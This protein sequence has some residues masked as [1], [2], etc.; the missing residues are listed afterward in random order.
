MRIKNKL[1]DYTQLSMFLF[2]ISKWKYVSRDRMLIYIF[3]PPPLPSPALPTL[4]S[5]TL[6]YPPQPSPAL[7]LPSPPFP[8]SSLPSPLL[9]SSYPPPSFPSPFN[10]CVFYS[11]YLFWSSNLAIQSPIVLS[12][13]EM[14]RVISVCC[15]NDFS[16]A[17]TGIFKFIFCNFRRTD[18]GQRGDGGGGG[19]GE[20]RRKEVIYYLINQIIHDELL[21]QI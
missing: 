19:G 14:K 7:P 18:R 12:T 16:L 5:P 2:S 9:T 17:L 21:Y 13:F 10:A 4:S 20:K 11:K 3:F 6:P 15:T 8:L 1:A